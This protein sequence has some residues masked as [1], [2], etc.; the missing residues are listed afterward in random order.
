MIRQILVPLDGSTVAESV[1]P[2]ARML[3]QLF[4]ASV[5]LFQAVE[6][7]D[8]GAVPSAPSAPLAAV[9]PPGIPPAE[10][11]SASDLEAAALERAHAYL[12]TIAGPLQHAGLT[13]HTKT[14]VDSPAAAIVDL[15]HDYD[16]IAMATHGRGGLGRWVYGSVA[17]KV[18]HLAPVPVLL[19]RASETPPVAIKRPGRLLI[20]LDG[21]LVA[22]QALPLATQVARDAGAT[23]TLVQ[24][25]FWAQATVSSYPYGYGVGAD[26]QRMMQEAEADAKRYLETVRARLVREGLTV[27][28]TVRPEPAADAILATATE[29]ECDLIVMSTHGRSGITRWLM[30]SIAGQV[31]RH[32]T[33]P[34]LLIRTTDESTVA[35]VSRATTTSRRS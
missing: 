2:S 33:L 6:P 20:A 14:S 18:L 16:L 32:A 35:T 30:G 10:L 31:V 28:I 19:I 27:E 13:V 23:V 29:S 12:V 17:E 7:L 5:T 25:T 4:N 3:A 15:A 8:P 22:E 24:S 9:I 11:P 26:V 1:L 34:I 21:S